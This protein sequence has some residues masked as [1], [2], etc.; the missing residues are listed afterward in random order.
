MYCPYQLNLAHKNNIYKEI[1]TTN[2]KLFP[3]SLFFTIFQIFKCATIKMS[4]NITIIYLFTYV[5]Y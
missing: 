3:I 4:R 5:N 1:F 2:E